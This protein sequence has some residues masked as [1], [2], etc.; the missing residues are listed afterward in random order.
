M[1]T[2]NIKY[3]INSLPSN[4]EKLSPQLQKLVET[5]DFCQ[6]DKVIN[7]DEVYKMWLVEINSE[8]NDKVFASYIHQLIQFDFIDRIDSKPKVEMTIEQKRT[9]FMKQMKLMTAE[10]RQALLDSCK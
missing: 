9:L 10:E 7:R 4:K 6:V 3:K 2:I 5:I 8:S 1:S